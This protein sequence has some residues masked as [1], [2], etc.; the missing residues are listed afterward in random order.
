MD[1]FS[2]RSV[3]HTVHHFRSK[4]RSFLLECDSNGVGRQGRRRLPGR[5]DAPQTA[6]RLRR[7]TAARRA[8]PRPNF[9]R[10]VRKFVELFGP[11]CSNG[12][13]GGGRDKHRK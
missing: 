13:N 6:D 12:E 9:R 10:Q 8:R 2:F 4:F 11:I 1:V 5:R 3:F 7:P